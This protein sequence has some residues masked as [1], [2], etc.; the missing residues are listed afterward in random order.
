MFKKLFPFVVIFMITSLACSLFTPKGEPTNTPPTA[1]AAQANES[2]ADAVTYKVEKNHA[3]VYASEGSL[4]AEVI[5]PK[6]IDLPSEWLK[7]REGV[8][9]LFQSGI[10]RKVE[11]TVTLY[12][13]AAFAID[14][15]WM[16]VGDTDLGKVNDGADFRAFAD[17]PGEYHFTAS[18]FGLAIGP[19]RSEG[20]KAGFVLADRRNADGNDGRPEYWLNLD[21]SAVQIGQ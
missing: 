1:V 4:L 19:F 14:G 6:G 18:S 17:T 9:Y 16:K 5:A 15:D 11:L 20:D 13:G 2:T 7:D 21:G 10:D 3:W 12:K 8:H